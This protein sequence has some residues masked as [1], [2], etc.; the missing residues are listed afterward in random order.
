M[1]PLSFKEFLVFKWKE[2]LSKLVWKKIDLEI[3]NEEI[4]FFY[5]EYSSKYEIYYPWEI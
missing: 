4:K 3:I 1:L 5:E 2:N